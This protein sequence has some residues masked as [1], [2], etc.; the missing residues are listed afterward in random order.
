ME[1]PPAS[2]SSSPPPAS[3][4]PPKDGGEGMDALADRLARRAADC[5]SDAEG[6]HGDERDVPEGEANAYE[7]SARLVRKLAASTQPASP[8]EE[9]KHYWL[10]EPGEKW[11]CERCGSTL[12]VHGEVPPPTHGCS[13]ASPS[14]VEDRYT[15]QEIAER[16]K[17]DEF[18]AAIFRDRTRLFNGE[19]VDLES[20]RA[21]EIRLVLRSAAD[22]LPLHVPATSEQETGEV[23]G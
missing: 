10:P 3:P 19:R 1:T 9:G 20:Q 21:L 6:H 12:D 18:V 17:A 4:L 23:E 16:L 13:P 22:Y 11:K 8:S 5:R 15:L 7:K 14:P 2:T